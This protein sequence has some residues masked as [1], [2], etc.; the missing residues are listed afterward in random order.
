MGSAESERRRPSRFAPV[1]ADASEQ[2]ANELRSYVDRNQLRPGDRLGTETELAAEFGVS[3]ATLREGLRLLAGSHLI[4]SAQ[5][6][7]GGIIVAN[8]LQGSMGQN[9][10]EVM[11]AMLANESIPLETMLEMRKVL[12]LAAVGMAAERA[13]D[14]AIGALEATVVAMERIGVLDEEFAAND[15]AFHEII[16]VAAG[17]ELIVAFSSWI[18]DVLVPALRDRIGPVLDAATLIAYHRAVLRPIRLRQPAAAQRAMAAHMDY[19][20]GFLTD[21]EPS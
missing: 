4:R 9:V 11:A 2:I 7:S 21:A 12:E 6:R 10:S 20:A 13:A 1:R 14:P 5:G 18:L 8:T 19:L 17:N 15:I 16:A 3:R